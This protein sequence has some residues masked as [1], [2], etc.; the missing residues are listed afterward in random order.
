MATEASLVGVSLVLDVD[1]AQVTVLPVSGDVV[2]TP[3]PGTVVDADA[4][5]VDMG[6]EGSVQMSSPEMSPKR[7]FAL[8]VR[9]GQAVQLPASGTRSVLLVSNGALALPDSGSMKFCSRNSRASLSCW[10]A[11]SARYTSR[12]ESVVLPFGDP[13]LSLLQKLRDEAHRFGVAYH[14][15]LRDK[16]LFDG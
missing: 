10:S 3:P 11:W 16:H 13:A 1:S 15:L 4:S 12:A 6:A 5:V 8:P 2:L 9:L 14:R 7:S